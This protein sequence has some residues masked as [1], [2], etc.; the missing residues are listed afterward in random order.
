MLRHFAVAT[1]VVMMA[2]CSSGGA[3]SGISQQQFSNL[4][5][6][7]GRWRGVENGAPV[8]WEFALQGESILNGRRFIDETFATPNDSTVVVL[9]AGVARM[10]HGPDVWT[11]RSITADN[12]N[13]QPES[14]AQSTVI[15]RRD[16][17]DTIAIARGNPGETAL[18]GGLVL[19]RVR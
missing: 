18:P 10:R 16:S 14:G 6:M 12:A 15:W 8:Y 11:A 5:F 1:A 13:F 17:A 3:S 4:R 19:T 7:E 2:A 9:Q